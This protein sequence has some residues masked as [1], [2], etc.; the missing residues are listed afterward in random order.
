[1]PAGEKVII[2]CLVSV[3]WLGHILKGYRCSCH[4]RNI[5][6]KITQVKPPLI[7]LCFIQSVHEHTSAEPLLFFAIVK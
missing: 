5:H 7:F 6:L 2:H 3:L 1:M 4:V